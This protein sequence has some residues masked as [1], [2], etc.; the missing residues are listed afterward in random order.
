[1]TNL[2]GT[3]KYGTHWLFYAKVAVTGLPS[4]VIHTIHCR[5]A[6]E[7]DVDSN[8]VR[9]FVPD[10]QL[11]AMKLLRDDTVYPIR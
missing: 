4:L 10:S 11:S 5:L 8:F 2:T 3:I 7:L 9:A 6:Q 1:M